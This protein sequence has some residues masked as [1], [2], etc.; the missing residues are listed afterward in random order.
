MSQEG[1]LNAEEKIEIIR[2]YQRGEISIAQAARDAGVGT[3]TI[4]RWIARYKAEG[5]GR[6]FTISEEPSLSVGTKVKGSA[7]VPIW[8]R[9]V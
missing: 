4:H 8:G 9:A 5:G 6:I 2:K 3:T 1:K 7:G